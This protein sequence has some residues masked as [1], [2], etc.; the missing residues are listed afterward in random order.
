MYSNEK[1]QSSL[2]F[3]LLV[4]ELLLI[5]FA[6]R[7]RV[8][9]GPHR[10]E[11]EERAHIVSYSCHGWIVCVSLPPSNLLNLLPFLVNNT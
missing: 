4:Y 8:S 2:A 9:P 1:T 11:Y 3:V 10:P 5:V 7:Y 6:Q